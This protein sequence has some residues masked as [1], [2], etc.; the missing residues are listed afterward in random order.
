M[1]EDRRYTAG[2]PDYAPEA[3]PV[4]EAAPRRAA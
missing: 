3:P 4:A 1:A 2:I